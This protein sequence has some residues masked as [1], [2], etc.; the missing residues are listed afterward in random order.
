MTMT[1]IETRVF[2]CDKCEYKSE[3]IRNL[4]EHMQINHEDNLIKIMVDKEYIDNVVDENKKLSRELD[5][6]KDD[7]ERLHDIFE[8]PAM[9][10]MQLK[11][12]LP[13]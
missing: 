7:F 10:T 12:T 5:P 13:K 4:I 6:I 11:L 9:E 1:D 2:P 3:K 8:S